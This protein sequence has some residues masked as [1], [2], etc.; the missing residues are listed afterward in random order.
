MDAREVAIN[1]V[2]TVMLRGWSN[3]SPTSL[4][5]DEV[6]KQLSDAGFTLC[7]EQVGWRRQ[8]PDGSFSLLDNLRDDQC[9]PVFVPLDSSRVSQSE[10]LDAD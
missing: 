10:E 7:G 6:L 5:A 2:D 8:W 4:I 9:I 1:A 3:L